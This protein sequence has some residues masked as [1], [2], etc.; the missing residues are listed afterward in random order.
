MKSAT[1]ARYCLSFMVALVR[2]G[3]ATEPVSL[4]QVA[5]ASGLSRRYLEQLAILLKNA[6]LV[7][8]VTGRNGGYLLAR[9]ADEITLGDVVTAAAGPIDFAA[10]SGDAKTCIRF[11]FC[12]C[13]PVWTIVNHS[14]RQVLDGYSLED[15]VDRRRLGRIR[16]RARAIETTNHDLIGGAGGAR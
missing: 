11:D 4:A 10:C 6:S 9:G 12:E 15:L 1:R 16:D 13:R 3:A 2:A 14:I 5:S 7:R 8:G